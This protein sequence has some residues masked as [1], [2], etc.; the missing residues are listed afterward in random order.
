MFDGNIKGIPILSV[1]GVLNDDYKGGE[2]IMFGD[3]ELK[4]PAGSG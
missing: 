1:L 2:F 3:T 4:L